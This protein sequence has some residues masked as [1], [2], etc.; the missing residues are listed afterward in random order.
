[1]NKVNMPGFF[2]NFQQISNKIRYRDPNIK[3]SYI[4]GLLIKADLSKIT[5]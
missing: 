5:M 3:K 2:V 1:M 4:F